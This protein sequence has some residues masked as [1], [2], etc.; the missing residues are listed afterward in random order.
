MFTVIRSTT[1]LIVGYKATSR[2]VGSFS[3]SVGL[4]RGNSDILART[5]Q[6][7]LR[8]LSA[9]SE[10]KTE[11]KS[12]AKNASASTSNAEAG[13]IEKN[14]ALESPDTKTPTSV[15][16]SMLNPDSLFVLAIPITT[17]RSY[18]HCNHKTSLLGDAQTKS[19]PW[20]AK[21]ETKAVGLAT[22]GWNK[23]LNSDKSV[24]KKI[25]L[26]VRM[27]LNT[28]PYDES[29]LRSF[30][31]KSQMIREI[32][33]ERQL[34]AH[35]EAQNVPVE[36]LTPIPVYHPRFQDPQAILTQM[37]QFRDQ[38]TM[39]H[40][41][42]AMLCAIGIP[43]SLPVALVPVIPNVPGFYLAYRLYCHIKALMGVRNLGYL[44]ETTND[45]I[46]VEDTTHL[47]FMECPELD[48]PFLEDAT[49]VKV[50]E[51]DSEDNERILITH[52]IIDRFV[53]QTGFKHLREDLSK[54]LDQETA[55][56]KKQLG[57]ET[58]E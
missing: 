3:R 40:R 19:V 41:K 47:D 32:N 29:C 31:S 21:V 22:T 46:A 15:S 37:H 55:R 6:I 35:L 39:H 34:T 16:K 52:E 24:N 30:P 11:D 44:L 45:D 48:A 23:L 2:S 4:H 25:V 1:K 51:E 58:V 43:I 27:L 10:L 50:K 14:V 18:V 33:G 56:I 38:L 12:D 26:G 17:H 57:L 49:F 53:E 8:H 5:S 9:A 7:S 13:S 42:Y 28:I 20:F 36:Q 54:A